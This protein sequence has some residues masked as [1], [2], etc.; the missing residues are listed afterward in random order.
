MSGTQTENTSDGGA[1]VYSIP[2]RK[3][4]PPLHSNIQG[5]DTQTESE[6]AGVVCMQAPPDTTAYSGVQCE[7]DYDTPR[8]S[9]KFPYVMDYSHLN[10]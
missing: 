3:A 1:V 7:H 5:R 4:P 8:P 6:G 2:T 9:A 10:H